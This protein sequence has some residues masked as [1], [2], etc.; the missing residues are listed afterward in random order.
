M[1][2][3]YVFTFINFCFFKHFFRVAVDQIDSLR[4]QLLHKDE[5]LKQLHKQFEY[6]EF[7]KIKIVQT[8]AQVEQDLSLK[9]HDLRKCKSQLSD[10]KDTLEVRFLTA[11]FVVLVVE[12]S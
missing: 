6:Q 12:S 8:L 10:K 5:E 9:S 4:R 11:S 2:L 7:E 3:T 1:L